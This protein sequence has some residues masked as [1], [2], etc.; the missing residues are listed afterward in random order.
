MFHQQSEDTGE[1][2][3]KSVSDDEDD[4][5]SSSNSDSQSNMSSP[6]TP[7]PKPKAV[8]RVRKISVGQPMRR[9]PPGEIVTL[10][11]MPTVPPSP[12]V[13]PQIRSIIDG[14]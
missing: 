8:E 5:Q 10:Q 11:Q 14:M 3:F 13:H 1:V 12:P 7:R 2:C 4:E 6:I 9:P